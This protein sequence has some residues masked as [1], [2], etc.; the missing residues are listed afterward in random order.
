MGEALTSYAADINLN[1]Q[2]TDTNVSN[3]KFDL[4]FDATKKGEKEIEKDINTEDLKLFVSV[5]VKDG[6]Y[7][8]NGQIDFEDC[9]F[10]LKN[11]QNKIELDSIQSGKNKEFYVEIEAKKDDLLN[12]N[13]LNMASKIK[14][15]GEYINNAGEEESID[16]EKQVKISWTSDNITDEN[17]PIKLNQ[18]VITNK[19]YNIG[20]VN[21]RVVQLE[22]TS[23]IEN[24]LYPIKSTEI[25]LD[26]PALGELY[27]ED[28]VVA[29][30]D[31]IATNGKNSTEFEKIEENTETEKEESKLGIWAYNKDE[32]KVN[33]VVNNKPV[34]N[35]V[36]WTKSGEDTFI[37]TYVY[38]EN[39]DLANFESSINSK[40]SLYGIKNAVLEEESVLSKENMEEIENVMIANLEGQDV[41]YKSNM[42]IGK[43]TEYE[44]DWTIGVGYSELANSFIIANDENKLILKN[45]ES[46]LEQSAITYYKSTY[47]NKEEF[48]NIFGENKEIILYYINEEGEGTEKT[49][50]I[51]SDTETDEEGNICLVNYEDNVVITST[52]I[53]EPISEGKLNI[54]HKKVL[55]TEGYNIEEINQIIKLKSVMILE[56]YNKL[57]NELDNELGEKIVDISATNLIE[58]VEPKTEVAIGVDKEKLSTTQENNINLTVTLKEDDLKYRLYRDPVIEIELPREVKS[59]NL[60][61]ATILNEEQTGLTIKSKEIVEKDNGN[62]VI[63]ITLEGEQTEYI[64]QD[65]EVLVNLDLQ[66]TKLMPTEESYINVKCIND[67]EVAQNYCS[68]KFVSE[69]GI[70]LANSISNYNNEEPEISVFKNETKAGLLSA[71]SETITATGKST[72]VNNTG[73][74]LENII[75]IGKNSVQVTMENAEIYYTKDAE[76]T[77]DSNWAQEYSDDVTGYKVVLNS[78]EKGEVLE[79]PYTLKIPAEL[80]TDKSIELGYSVYNGT[81]KLEESPK[82]VLETEKEVKLALEVEPLIE[83]GE[84]VY[85]E[86]ILSYNI[87]VTNIGDTIARNI[88]INNP[89]PEGTTIIDGYQNSWLIEELEAGK[90]VTKTIQVI[91]DKLAED[92]TEKTITN[93]TTVTAP[94]IQH[95]LTNTIENKVELKKEIIQ[96]NTKSNYGKVFY[97][98]DKILHVI[99]I[100]N[101]TDEPITNFTVKREIPE[102][103]EYYL[104]GTEGTIEG[105][106]YSF[107]EENKIAIWEIEKIE[108]K[109]TVNLSLIIV[110]KALENKEIQPLIYTFSLERNNE[111]LQT[112]KRHDGDIVKPSLEIEFTSS[113][114]EE[115]KIGEEIIYELNIKNK[116]D[117]E[118]LANIDIDI[119]EGLLTKGITTEQEGTTDTE[120]VADN[121]KII[122]SKSVKGQ[123]SLKVIINAEVTDS[124]SQTSE[125]NAV[126]TVTVKGRNNDGTQE[127]ERI[128]FEKYVQ[129]TVEVF[130]EPEEPEQPENPEEPEQPE[131]PQEPEQPENPEEPEQPENPQEPGRTEQEEKIYKIS[132]LAWLD[133]NENGEQEGTEKL[134]KGILVKIKDAKTKEYLKNENGDNLTVIT[135]QNGAYKF[136]GLK[137]G[138]YVIEFEYDNKTYKLTPKAGKDSKANVVTTG[139]NTVTKTNTITITNKDINNINIGLALNPIYDLKLD[140]YVSKIT[141]QNSAG[142]KIYNYDKE[143]LAKVDIKAKQ[144]AGSTV[145]IEYIIEVTNNGEVPGY[146]K[147]I[148]DY[149]SPELKFNSE[150]NTSWYEGTDKNLY[151]IELAN[152]IIKPG[153]SKQV[154]LVV[155]KTMTEK[156]TGLV[157]NTAEIYEDFNEYALEDVNSIAG[158]KMEKENDMSAADVIITV[159]TGSPIL[160]IGI[161]IGSMLVLGLGIYLINKKVIMRRVI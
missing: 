135:N 39:A 97:E 136:E 143:Q 67:E 35:K 138:K 40:I 32:H 20:G 78:L 123:E 85:E 158:N 93:I 46:E 17:N 157:N 76:V 96:I 121:N 139:K 140:K 5:E 133:E 137:A 59:V 131:N 79:I 60:K 43:E 22:V 83:D 26:V 21:K 50:T 86:N 155:T 99:Q 110:A 25:E 153:E 82:I 24:N 88:Q 15:T 108:A 117:F 142:T 18:K 98:G 53:I 151:C 91:V 104:G 89:V 69:Q 141:V 152:D 37:V 1:D 6:G 81:I 2:N 100:T 146:A 73:D 54:K 106:E 147:T 63:N 87:K 92:E 150:L 130:V 148:V 71:N 47:I 111:L 11:N 56:A 23:G 122:L 58:M 145:I 120:T 36:S 107:D 55:K 90:S 72:I 8:S 14:L 159:S 134:L 94:F 28:V 80:G 45:G 84:T 118:T 38:E 3:V 115:I 9:N 70:L 41:I 52:G 95:E 27:P 51:N 156:N 114:L 66:T 74:N 113:K 160:Y 161:I 65:V 61:E 33:I 103:T 102:G 62:K 126:A 48:L 112:F 68:V 42:N 19:I 109:A 105:I 75:I 128:L 154:K 30:Y 149:L 57:D 101:P 129:S 132:G 13:L 119:P 34:E 116:T 4:Y 31:T 64:G 12:L 127:E 124:F 49:I 125:L 29:S 44:E 10:R 144:L 16:T 7:L 77:L